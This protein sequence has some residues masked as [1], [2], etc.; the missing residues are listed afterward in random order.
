MPK[1]VYPGKKISWKRTITDREILLFAELSGDKAIH[2][3]QKDSD[4]RLVAHGL[5]TAT[6]PTKLGGDLDYIA[7]SIQF[8]FVYPVCSG[9]TL[10][11]VGI[12]D[13]VMKKPGRFKIKF[14]FTVTNQHNKLV[15]KGKSSGMI[16]D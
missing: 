12:V 10:T 4:G 15:L 2:H 7:R 8:D 5:F 6:L 13:A 3:V 14:S 1:N 16:R 9:D 11:C